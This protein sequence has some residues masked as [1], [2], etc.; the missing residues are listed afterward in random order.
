MKVI[1]ESNVQVDHT[2]EYKRMLKDVLD[3]M[4]AHEKKA[5]EDVIKAG[6]YL[7]E[8]KKH[9]KHGEWNK[10]L[11]D[12]G[13]SKKT[14]ERYMGCYKYLSKNDH[15]VDFENK[16]Q[17]FALL[18][19]KNDIESFLAEHTDI[20][21]KTVQEIKSLVSAHRKKDNPS[22]DSKTP[23]VLGETLKPEEEENVHAETNEDIFKLKRELET[24]KQ[25]YLELKEKGARYTQDLEQQLKEYKE[26]IE[27]M[28]SNYESVQEAIVLDKTFKRFVRTIPNAEIK[29]YTQFVWEQVRE[30]FSNTYG[31]STLSQI[32]KNVPF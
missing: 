13:L 26:E 11:E 25:R 16:Q 29:D 22:I 10:W 24:L 23:S 15:V 30:W 4:N 1:T 2:E 3:D 7:T 6:E 32:P 9:V 28:K 8:A 14:S 17:I 31:Q 12:S 19:L 5:L 18:P 21:D 20:Y 27:S